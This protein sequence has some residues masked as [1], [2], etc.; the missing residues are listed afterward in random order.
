VSTA[1]LDAAEKINDDAVRVAQQRL[2]IAVLDANKHCRLYRLPASFQLLTCRPTRLLDSHPL[3]IKLV[4]R[5]TAD[6]LTTVDNDGRGLLQWQWRGEEYRGDQCPA[7][8]EGQGASL[9][10]KVDFDSVINSVIS[11]KA[12][13]VSLF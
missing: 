6:L 8:R 10:R 4:G 11:R 2:V 7:A 5:S 1:G 12:R 13:I 9:T 3:I